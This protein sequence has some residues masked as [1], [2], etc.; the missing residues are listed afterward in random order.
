MTPY[1]REIEKL[2][3]R[4]VKVVSKGESYI[5]RYYDLIDEVIS[6]NKSNI[7]Q[8][9]L[10]RFKIDT[11]KFNTID[12][13]KKNTFKRISFFIQSTTNKNLDSLLQKKKVYR[14]GINFYDSLTQKYLGDISETDTS[15]ISNV[16]DVFTF[17]PDRLT[18]AIPQFLTSSQ[19]TL[20]YKTFSVVYYGPNLYECDTQYTWS[21]TNQITPTYS[22]YW[23][24]ILPGTTSYTQILG[25]TSTIVEK[26]TLAIDYLRTFT[27]SVF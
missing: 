3:N 5:Y 27:Y 11:T 25:P 10:L 17:V 18:N 1:R 4:I 2:Y 21:Y 20:T 9:V 16:L 19:I 15:T 22:N 26:Y 12:D 24:Q 14:L 23:H 13:L 7:L 6:Y 8:D